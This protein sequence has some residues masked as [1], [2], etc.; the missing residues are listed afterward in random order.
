MARS[1]SFLLKL[2]ELESSLVRLRGAGAGSSMGIESVLFSL[3]RVGF[4]TA[5]S[6][7]TADT[8]PEE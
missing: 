1:G 8:A 3:A 5:V 7:G 4:N 2:D 6:T